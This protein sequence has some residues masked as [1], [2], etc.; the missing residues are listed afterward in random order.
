MNQLQ[1]SKRKRSVPKHAPYISEA[2]VL[3][4][5]RL[6]LILFFW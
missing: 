1:K 3:A 4:P 5:L 6:D 2:E